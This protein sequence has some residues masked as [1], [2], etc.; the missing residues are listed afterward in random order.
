MSFHSARLFNQ[1]SRFTRAYLGETIKLGRALGISRAGRPD[2]GLD[3][4]G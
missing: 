1:F 2:A 4:R 3:S